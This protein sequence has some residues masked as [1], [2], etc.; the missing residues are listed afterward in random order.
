[1]EERRQEISLRLPVLGREQ[2][3]PDA[4]PAI[5]FGVVA[6]MPGTLGFH[7]AR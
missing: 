2:D 3:S 4:G 1:M 5:A 6:R 7:R